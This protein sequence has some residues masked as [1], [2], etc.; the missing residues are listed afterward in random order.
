MA[1]VKD[2]GSTREFST[3]AHR[4]NA[5]GKGRCD[6]LP[7]KQVAEIM[8][9]NVIREIARFFEDF[10]PEH[11]RQAIRYSLTTIIEYQGNY[12]TMFLETSHLY[13][14]GA[15]KYGPNNWKKGMPLTVYLDSGTRHYFKALRGDDDEP[16]Y[17]GFVWNLLGA[18]W[19]IDNVENSLEQFKEDTQNWKN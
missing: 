6:L 10:D 18:L 11:L 19:S 4:D 9:D 13:E 5:E 1:K 15:N 14:D 7:L 12:E 16:H 17:R 8:D 3:G 2:S